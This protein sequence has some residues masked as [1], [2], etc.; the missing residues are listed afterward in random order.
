[1]PINSRRALTP[2][3]PSLIRSTSGEVYISG[4]AAL[5]YDQDE[6]GT[7]YALAED[8]VEQI[9]PGAFD[10]ALKE[11]QI[12][13]GLFNHDMNLVLGSTRS[14][15]LQLATDNL[16][17]RYSIRVGDTTIAHDVCEQ[18]SRG[19]V[20]GC[21]FSFTVKQQS[22]IEKSGLLIRVLQ[23]VDLYDVGPVT[24][25]AYKATWCAVQN[26]GDRSFIPGPSRAEI[27]A[28]ALQVEGDA[29]CP[30]GRLQV[31]ARARQVQLELA[32]LALLAR[33]V[34]V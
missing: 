2:A 30:A 20:S 12:V 17:L 23:D 32:H 9:A 18:V 31:L 34:R 8:I 15:T 14:G 1:M 5:Y 6:P 29:R 7:T 22:L 21:S 28:R 25:P 33:C 3:R 13:A 26:S 27:L 16:G 11:K 24:R 4:Y 19:D 10:R